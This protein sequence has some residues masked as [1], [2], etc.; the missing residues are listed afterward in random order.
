MRDELKSIVGLKPKVGFQIARGSQLL[1][2]K[3]ARHYF[4]SI[5]A[6]GKEWSLG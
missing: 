3:L 2:Q 6:L 5:F 1:V 4:E